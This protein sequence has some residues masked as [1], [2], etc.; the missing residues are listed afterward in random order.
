MQPLLFRD[1]G[2]KKDLKSLWITTGIKKASKHKQRLY[3]KFLKNRNSLNG[4]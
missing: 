3:K 1:K 2:Y 4:S